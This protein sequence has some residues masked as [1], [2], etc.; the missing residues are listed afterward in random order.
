GRVV[1]D[2]FEAVAWARLAT[3]FLVPLPPVEGGAVEGGALEVVR[4]AAADCQITPGANLADEPRDDVVLPPGWRGA[5]SGPGSGAE[6]G[7]ESTVTP[8]AVAARAALGRAVFVAAVLRE[9]RRLTIAYAGQRQ[10]FGRPIAEFQAVAH[11]LT[12]IAAE[13]DAADAIVRLALTADVD[14]VRLLSGIAKARCSVA[15]VRVAASAHQV[16]GAMGVSEEYP[17]GRLT[18]QLWS[19]A[20]E[21]GDERYWQRQLGAVVGQAEAAGP[22]GLWSTVLRLGSR[23][24]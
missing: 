7:A 11:H 17:L 4:V 2:R 15:A 20:G 14:R 23:T 3:E 12:L 24:A 22:D 6:S 18:K 13:S 1:G 21:D 10:Q 5:R 9:V 19:A 8:A 16:H